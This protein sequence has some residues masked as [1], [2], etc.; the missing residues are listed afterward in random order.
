MELGLNELFG[1]SYR[2]LYL[3]YETMPLNLRN[4]KYRVKV[5]AREVVDTLADSQI[6]S[7]M[8]YVLH[9]DSINSCSNQVNLN[10]SNPLHHR[11][12]QASNLCLEIMEQTDSEEVACCNLGQMS[13]K[14]FVLGRHGRFDFKMFGYVVR[15]M[16]K[17]LDRV[18]DRNRYVFPEA[19]TSNMRHRPIG[20][21]VSG[22][23]DMLDIMG[24][25]Y[26]SDEASELN[27][28]IF[29]CMYY[30]AMVAS[31][32]LAIKNGPYSTFWGSPLSEG[33]FSFDLWKI[34]RAHLAPTEIEPDP[35]QPSEWN[36]QAL[37]IDGLG[38]ILNPSWDDLR[39]LVMEYGVR[40]SQ[41]IA[42]MPSASTSRLMGNA[43]NTE[44]HQSNLYIR[45]F[46]K[47]SAVIINPQLFTELDGDLKLWSRDVAEFIVSQAGSVAKLSDFLLTTAADD[48]ERAKVTR[49]QPQLA[50]LCARYKT[51]FEIKQLK[52]VEQTAARHRYVC[53]GISFNVYLAK[54]TRAMLRNLHLATWK[55][56]LKTGIYYLREPVPSEAP[57]YAR[58]SSRVKAFLT[59]P[60]MRMLS[61]HHE[62]F[63][64][65]GQ[66]TVQHRTTVEL[67]DEPA[68]R[69]AAKKAVKFA[70]PTPLVA[71]TEDEEQKAFA[72]LLEADLEVV[73]ADMMV[74]QAARDSAEVAPTC[75]RQAG[76]ASCE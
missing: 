47:A 19:K 8:P 66:T 73:S 54:P 37:M 43:E 11:T 53:Q 1:N 6:M 34:R 17:Y 36:Q 76:C 2:E 31:L 28:Q 24:I 49:L 75:K 62:P 12:I 56:G 51:M 67:I 45:N 7:G 59:G 5:S 35:V 39:K 72:A 57:E 69:T 30:N 27:R 9:K 38:E 16:V 29:A 48:E 70:P 40:N 52:A 65:A 74:A 44:A 33:K 63:P 46:M 3:H 58:T 21:G 22:Y 55:S 15:S 68:P 26:E 41:M 71:T 4:D 13:L 64:Q 50:S 32:E 10:S 42:V 20:L 25:A 60:V 18:I 23:A 14:A 61:V